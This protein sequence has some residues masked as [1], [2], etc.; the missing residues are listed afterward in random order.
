M[1]RNECNGFVPEGENNY[2]DALRDEYQTKQKNLVLRLQAATVE[3]EKAILENEIAELRST[4]QAK[5]SG[6]KWNLY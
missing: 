3:T 6:A 2:L 1:K 5:V 4:Y